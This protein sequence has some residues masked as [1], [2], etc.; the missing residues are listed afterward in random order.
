M[1]TTVATRGSHSSPLPPSAAS[2]MPATHPASTTTPS[3]PL[4][5]RAGRCA[6]STR[7][8]WCPTGRGLV[9]DSVLMRCSF[10][11]K[12][13]IKVI[14][15]YWTACKTAR[16]PAAEKRSTRQPHCEEDHAERDERGAG[17]PLGRLAPSRTEPGAEAD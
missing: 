12:N 17:H 5:A 3:L 4:T 1:I 13:D 2:T 6:I 9:T 11:G 15:H 10:F 14:S 7:A 16:D 8:P